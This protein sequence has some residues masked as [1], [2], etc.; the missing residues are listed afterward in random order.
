[1]T[2]S[3]HSSTDIGHVQVLLI[4]TEHCLRMSDDNVERCLNDFLLVSHIRCELPKL[5]KNSRGMDLS[6]CLPT[7]LFGGFK[8]IC[9]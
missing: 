5:S 4:S 8:F 9:N 6:L 3:T 2:N 7:L 1:M